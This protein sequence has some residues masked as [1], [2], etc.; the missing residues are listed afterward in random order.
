MK[1]GEISKLSGIPSET[2][3]YYISLGLLN[4]ERRNN[5]YHFSSEDWQDI[6]RIQQLKEMR[7]PLK[8]IETVIRFGRTSNWVEPAIWQE[9]GSIL[10]EQA[11]TLQR[12]QQELQQ[13]IQRISRELER[14]ASHNNEE[15]HFHSGVP[16]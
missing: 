8:E 3:R 6:Q 11:K 4:P 16:L 5:Q 15:A 10:L 7:F 14:V 2:I 13:S 12:E 9:Y 1:I